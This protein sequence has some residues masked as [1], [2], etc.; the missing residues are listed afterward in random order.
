MHSIDELIRNLRSGD[1]AAHA[2]IL[3]GRSR[4]ARERF[5]DELTAGLGCT[6]LDIVRMEMSG[7]NAYKV[8]DAS[9]FIDRLMMDAYGDFLVGVIDD[10]DR[11]TDIVQNKLLK[12]IEEPGSSVVILLGT[13]NPDSLL[14]TVRS[15]CMDLRISDY[16]FEGEDPDEAAKAEEVRQAAALITD[17]S[18][19][20]VFREAAGKCVKSK[21]DALALIDAL[22]DALRERMLTGEDA[23]ADAEKIELAE[24]A[25][26]DIERDMDKV[27][28]L[29]RLW[30]ELN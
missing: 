18:A 17:G 7:K 28:A 5:I 10:A 8:D 25:R 15:R 3:E 23:A 30:L 13:P 20:H 26:M 19:F 21:A 1:S 24:T 27:K 6:A 16:G 11:L 9:A 2:Y 29:K 14:S 4:E 12:T 22:E